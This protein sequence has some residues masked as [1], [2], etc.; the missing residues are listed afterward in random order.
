[1]TTA[2]DMRL[3]A[4]N[5]LNYMCKRGAEPTGFPDSLN[6]LQDDTSSYRI[7]VTRQ[8]TNTVIVIVHTEM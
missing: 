1:M 5:L 3:T 7:V 2:R 6:T 4:A 8:V